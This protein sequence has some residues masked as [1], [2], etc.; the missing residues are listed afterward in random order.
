MWT[1]YSNPVPRRRRT[2]H[3]TCM[4]LVVL[5]TAGAPAVARAQPQS[6]A[7]ADSP[8]ATRV[9]TLA[10]V[11]QIART[12]QPQ[13]LVAR[14]QTSVAEGQ[15]QSA[16][17][18][19]LPQITATGQYTRETGNYVSR[20][21][22]VPQTMITF[23]GQ[24]AMVTT[25]GAA[26]SLSQSYDVWNF[27]LNATQLIYDFGQTSEKYQAAKA[28]VDAQRFNETTT[29]IQILLNVRRMYFNARAMKELVNVARE[30]LDD[31]D[32]H[33]A[34]VQGMVDV[35]TQ[36]PIALAQ[37]KAAVANARVQLI[38]AQNNYET[39]KAQLNQ[40]AGI[41]GG[42]DYDVGNEEVVPVDDEDQ[43]LET[44][45][46]KAFQGRPELAQLEKLRVAQEAT[47]SSAKGTYGPAFSA[48]A[49]FTE[50][51]LAL[52]TLVPNWSAGL[53]LNW[54]LFQGGLTI[55]L[56]HQAEAWSAEHRCAEVARRAPNPPRRRLGQARRSCRQGH[57][58]LGRGR[59]DERPRAAAAGR[60][61]LCDGCWQHHRAQRRTGRL[62]ERRSTA[63]AGALR[64]RL[65]AGPTPRRPGTNMMHDDPIAAGSP[66]PLRH[67]HPIDG[68]P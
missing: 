57:H 6:P 29:R 27:G 13:A 53:L 31:Q 60:T 64:A 2:P 36:P 58:R 22:F 38:T 44:L 34:Q 54:P 23:N 47:L 21:G 4:A 68:F 9:L 12:Q 40:A 35:G 52:D 14:A 26:T 17:A 63:R 32:K 41:P 67:C 33:L 62:H 10:A 46:G 8:Q 7:G 56:V 37:Q 5:G 24:P 66:P 39:S 42:T 28:T 3:A 15:A 59:S 1:L 19:L 50:A 43:P 61:A 48:A 18:P 51:G 30:T 20:P 45:V 49:G 65:R 25:S 16:R 55:G 11:E